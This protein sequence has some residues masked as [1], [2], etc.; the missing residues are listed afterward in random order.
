ME[1]TVKW[2]SE[3]KGYGFIVGDDGIE[4]YFNVRSING[5][6]LPN[7]GSTVTFTSAEGN[8]GPRATNV[9]IM[10]Q[11]TQ[12]TDD[13]VQCQHCNKRIVPRIITDRGTLS[14]SVCPFCGGTVKNFNSY[15]WVIG[16]IVFV[17]F[18]ILITR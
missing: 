16:V 10:H 18:V 15:G 1:G 6:T 13:R 7:N 8:K 9:E 4:R 12:H 2:F 17:I 14:H 11:A 3:E 5:A